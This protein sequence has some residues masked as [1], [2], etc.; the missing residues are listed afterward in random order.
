[1]QASIMKIDTHQHAWNFREQDFPWI[2]EGMP[3]L[4]QN[5][6]LADVWPDM[7][8]CGVTAAVAVQARGTLAETDFLLAEAACNPQIL[9]VV[10]WVDLMAPELPAQLDRWSGNSV[11]R[12]FRH[13]LQDEPDIPAMVDSAAFNAAMALLQN[14]QLVYDVL[15]FDHQMPLVLDFCARHDRHWL[16]LDHVGKPA[17]RDWFKHPQVSRR[18]ADSLSELASMPHVMCKLSGLVTEADWRVNGGLQ[19]ADERVIHACFDQ[20]LDLFGPQRLLFGSD[21]PV[22]QLAASYGTVHQLAQTWAD[23]RLSESEQQSFW[24]GN[25]QLCYG[26]KWA[27]APTHRTEGHP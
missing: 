18:W 15:V 7:S 24:A 23:T 26:L 12:G 21:W 4:R 11:L 5:R 27:K 8:A 19:P 6:G 14:R 2:D 22:C 25:A 17:V 3:V 1:M 9:G 16:V 13:I 20:A 10:G